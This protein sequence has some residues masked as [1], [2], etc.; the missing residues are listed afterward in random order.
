MTNDYEEKEEKQEHVTEIWRYLFIGLLT[1]SAA[2]MAWGVSQV[3]AGI[4][5][6]GGKQDQF[7]FNF[8]NYVTSMEHRVSVLEDYEKQQDVARSRLERDFENYR[9]ERDAARGRSGER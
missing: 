7:L 4:D 9:E 5:K 1:L 3:T 8:Q 2:I 6:V